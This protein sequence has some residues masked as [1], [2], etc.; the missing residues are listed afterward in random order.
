VYVQG[1][2][3][4]VLLAHMDT[5]YDVAPE[6]VIENGNK[7]QTPIGSKAG[8]GGDNRCGCY[9]LFEVAKWEQ[10]PSLLFCC[11]EEN[12]GGGTRGFNTA[13]DWSKFKCFIEVDAPNFGVFYSGATSNQTLNDFMSEEIGLYELP[14]SY[15]DISEICTAGNPPGVTI[16]AAYYNQHD[17]DREW[18]STTGVQ[19]QLMVI[20]NICDHIDRLDYSVVEKAPL[21]TTGYAK[22]LA[23]YNTITMCD[24]CHGSLAPT[25][26]ECVNFEECWEDLC[27]CPYYDG[28]CFECDQ[29]NIC[30]IHGQEQQYMILDNE[31][32]EE[33]N[34][35]H[36]EPSANEKA[37]KGKKGN[38]SKR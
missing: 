30:N 10:R 34:Y 24:E 8:V 9:I 22:T 25:G 19:C 16:G 6:T 32:R 26:N 35:V 4:F 14:T 13:Y 7:L 31:E 15:N 5:V 21:I 29:Y 23:E 38:Q 17:S 3:P 2:L 12:A 36:F 1:T 37:R 11:D 18:I 20:K 33:Q 27:T 28:E